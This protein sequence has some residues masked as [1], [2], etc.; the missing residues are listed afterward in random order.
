MTYSPFYFKFHISSARGKRGEYKLNQNK[1]SQLK[2]FL[3]AL[4][5]NESTI[6]MVLGAIVILVVGI[7]TV[8][9]FKDK[10]AEV[11][12]TGVSTS[13]TKEHV[14]V[15]GESLWSIAEDYYG[16]G[17][18]WVGLAKANNLTNYELEIG[19]TL[20]LPE[21]IAQEPTAT[22][23]EIVNLTNSISENSYTVVKGD[24]LWDIAVRAYG[25]GYKWVEIASMNKL[26]NPN[27]IHAGNVLTLPR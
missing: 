6:S 9:Y 10:K 18:N 1:N 23:Q 16:S 15:S 26:E 11:T 12:D 17:Y 21:V 5:T 22:N 19:Q 2:N 13:T 24:T 8:N 25:D 4:K 14:V 7:S 3:K 20:T 27:I